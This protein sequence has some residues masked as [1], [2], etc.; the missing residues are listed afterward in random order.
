MIYSRD[1][2]TV[3]DGGGFAPQWHEPTPVPEAPEVPIEPIQ[4]HKSFIDLSFLKKLETDDLLII[5]IGILL[6]LDSDMS[7]DMILLFIAAMLFL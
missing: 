6:L 1:F 3:Q 7:S 5:A 2:G 4:T